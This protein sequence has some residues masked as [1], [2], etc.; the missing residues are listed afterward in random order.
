MADSKIIHWINLCF[1]TLDA[2]VSCNFGSAKVGFLLGT[3]V[4]DRAVSRHDHSPPR[5]IYP[6]RRPISIF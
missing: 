2:N 3:K 6:P 5:K 4:S 1:V